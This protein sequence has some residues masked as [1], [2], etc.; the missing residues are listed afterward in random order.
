MKTKKLKYYIEVRRWEP[1]RVR[2]A[3]IIVPGNWSRPYTRQFKTPL[4]REA[5]IKKNKDEWEAASA[6]DGHPLYN[7]KLLN[8]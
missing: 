6:P 1:D 5:F 3:G 8:H 7:I 4:E 2:T